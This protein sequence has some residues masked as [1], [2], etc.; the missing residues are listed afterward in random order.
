MIEIFERVGFTVRLLN[1]ERFE[2]LPLPRYKMDP[3]FKDLPDDELMVWGF[4]VLLY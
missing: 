2:R 4:D 3:G 1:V